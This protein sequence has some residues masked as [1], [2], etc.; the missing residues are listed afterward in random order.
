ML[1]TI[2]QVNRKLLFAL[3]QFLRSTTLPTTSAGSFNAGAGTFANEITLK[4]RERTED[5]KYQLA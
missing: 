4:F 1:I 3:A 5:M 2:I